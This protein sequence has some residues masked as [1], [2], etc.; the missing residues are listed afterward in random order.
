VTTQRAHLLRVAALATV[1]S[2]TLVAWQRPA[3]VSQPLDAVAADLDA[4]V[5][6]ALPTNVTPG[7]AVAVVRGTDVLYAKGFGF[8]DQERGRRVTADTQFYI[9]STTKSFTAL[10]AT[11]L[12]SRGV[13]DLDAPLSRALPRAKLHP[14]LLADQI[15][16]RDLLTHTHGIMPGGPVDVRTAFTGDFTNEQLLDLVAFHAPAST[17]RAFA[18]S[19]LG[20]NIFSLA[21][22]D[23]FKEGWKQVLQREVFDPLGMRSTTA[24]ISKT[25]PNRLAQPYELRPNGPQRVDYVKRDENMQA[26]GGHVSTA[27]DLARY[28]MAHL[29]GGRIGGRQA[30]PEAAVRATHRQQ[31]EQKRTFGSFQ[32]FGWG[33]GWDLATYDGD[34]IMQRFGGFQ[35]FHSHVSFM[36]ERN[37]GVVVLANGG[38]ASGLVADVVATYAYDRVLAKP[39]LTARTEERWNAFADELARGRG[40]IAKDL[41]TRQARPQTPPLGWDAYV[42]TYENPALGRMVWTLENG[43]L[44]VRMGVARSDVEVYN[45]AQYQ[46]RV[47]LTGGGSVVTFDVPAGGRRP[48]GFRFFDQAFVRVDK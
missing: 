3:G 34:T 33:L 28:L 4:F 46:L 37:I 11:L 5:A 36:P 47:E 41:A 12:A 7:L 31:V 15:T 30:L 18:Y 38:G 35:G 43:R 27:N 24:W 29:N 25:D 26:A 45:G 22:D 40:A 6:R 39:G 16:L 8:A 13:I 21:L 23:K 2:T 10:V 48:T 17:G 20:Y 42:G 44:Q 9:A 1:L 19:N 14:Q 32:R